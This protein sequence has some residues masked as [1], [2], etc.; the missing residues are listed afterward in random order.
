MRIKRSL[1]LFGFLAMP[2]AGCGGG[3]GGNGTP[4]PS[5]SPSG[6][7]SV[8]AVARV[9]QGATAP[10]AFAFGLGLLPTD[11]AWK[12][13]PDQI[14]VKL[15]RL[16]FEGLTAETGTGADLVD[17]IV[18]YDRAAAA[19]DPLLDCPFAIAPGTYTSMNLFLDPVADVLIADAVNGI[20]TDPASASGLSSVAP[21]GGAAFVPVT[22]TLGGGFE[23]FFTAPL[24]VGTADVL[25]LSVLVDAIQTTQVTVSGGGATLEF[26]DYYPAVVV[27]TLGAPGAPQYYTSQGTANSYNGSLVLPH[28]LRIYYEAGVGA[29]PVRLSLD[30]LATTINACQAGGFGYVFPGDPATSPPSSSG[31]R[32]GGWLAVDPSNVICAAVGSNSEFTA[33]HSYFRMGYVPNLGDSTTLSCELTSTPTPP[34]SGNTYEAGCPPIV[35]V[36]GSASLMLVAN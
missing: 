8:S 29:Q 15:T 11:G 6:T 17:C 16:N 33:Y 13:S 20:Y 23:Q 26:G 1:V 21:A 9:F 3:G 12:V 30:Q 5:P 2:F 18:T 14:R 7:P 22:S 19:L 4:T 25:S 34:S 31:D 36:L 35:S 28:F 32:A 24:V 10:P 27:P